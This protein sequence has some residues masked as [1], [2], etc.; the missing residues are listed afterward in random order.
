MSLDPEVRSSWCGLMDALRPPA[1]YRL[2]AA[3]G[4]SFG[5]TFDALVASLLAMLDS[6]A[7]GLAEDP[8]AGLL[9]A[10]R[11]SD[12]VRVFVHAGS[13]SGTTSGIPSRL[14]GLLDRMIVAVRPTTG[15]FHP[16]LWV[17]RYQP[18][19][20]LRPSPDIMRVIVGSRNLA[21]SSSF[22]LGSIVEGEVGSG[23]T[24]LGDDVAHALTSCLRYSA[25]QCR[26]VAGMPALVRQTAFTVPDE[27]RGAY[28]LRWQG[29]RGQ[30]QIS[31]LP[32]SFHRALVL[33]PFLGADLVRELLA[34]SRAIRIVSTPTAYRKLDDATFAA[35]RD[36]AR[37]QKSPAMY[38]VGDDFG[39][40]ENG[41]LDG[42][43]AKLLIVDNGKEHDSL[44]FLGSANATGA[45]W[46]LI[47]AGNVECLVELRPGLSMDRLVSE[48]LLGKRAAPKPWIRE[49]EPTDR[50]PFTAEE[51]LY[52]KLTALTRTLAAKRFSV[53]YDVRTRVL[54]VRL[55]DSENT[56]SVQLGDGHA[57]IECVPLGV[58][59][60][61]PQWQPI[62]ELASG[63]LLFPDVELSAVS[64]FLVL[65]ATVGATAVSRIAMA[66]LEVSDAVIADR[67]AAARHH[68]LSNARTEDILAALVFGINRLRRD[69]THVTRG[70]GESHRSP[71][72]IALDTV[73]LERVLQAIAEN[74]DLLREMRLLLGGRSD[75]AFARFQEALEDAIGVVAGGSS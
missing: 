4:T 67:D 71:M 72:A 5:M 15:V 23:S 54:S 34:R 53:S 41:H 37:L 17:L 62:S 42:L 35:L 20:G 64:A 51:E 26:A 63:P 12:R 55:A 7:E 57:R 47:G 22:E 50:T 52:D 58:F 28:R 14:A 16:K 21:P 10:T 65:R 2:G 25:R 48:F 44:T 61:S 31:N 46:G 75:D 56:S 1:G 27:G 66:D 24:P 69:G 38:V 11:L 49:Y 68:L 3:I 60:D 33:S 59:E 45:G 29:S 8:L 74:P 70:N 18:A 19:S 9:A 40:E 13:I 32:A 36:R 43:H 39:D 73:S 30:R 6:E